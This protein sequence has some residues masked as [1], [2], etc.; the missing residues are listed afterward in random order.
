MR[1][2]RR[3]DE[4]PSWTELARIPQPTRKLE[5][6]ETTHARPEKCERLVEERFDGSLQRIDERR[7]CFKGRLISAIFAPGE[8]DRADL[9]PIG[10]G[11]AP[12]AVGEVAASSVRK[13]EEAELC[14]RRWRTTTEPQ[15][16]LV[17]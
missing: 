9:D 15:L 13:A 3:C 14:R 10:N 4:Q 1:R 11:V 2:R 8:L 6:N 7:K 12:C 16:R 5:A 17:V